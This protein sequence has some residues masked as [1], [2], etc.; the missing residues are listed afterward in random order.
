M[1]FKSTQR[2][3]IKHPLLLPSTSF[4]LWLRV[5]RHWFLGPTF[6]LSFHSWSPSTLSIIGYH[7]QTKKVNEVKSGGF[8]SP[9]QTPQTSVCRSMMSCPTR[10]MVVPAFS[11]STECSSRGEAA[12][13]SRSLRTH[14]GG[15]CWFPRTP[16]HGLSIVPCCLSCWGTKR[17]H[18][19]TGV[20]HQAVSKFNQKWNGPH[21]I[22]GDFL[23]MKVVIWGKLFLLEASEISDCVSA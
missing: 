3:Y 23:I 11:H 8:S 16:S 17:R 20:T 6:L 14:A 21:Y 9:P 22:T 12:R 5:W 4:L 7:F 13:G 2:S 15:D 18:F 19:N 1:L 10:G